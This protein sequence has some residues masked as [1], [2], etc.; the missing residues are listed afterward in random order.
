MIE[1]LFQPAPQ[2]SVEEGVKAL[3]SNAQDGIRRACYDCEDRIRQEPGKAMLA[4]AAAGYL[5]HRLPVRAILVTQ[6]KVLAALARPALVAFGAAKVCEYLQKR[7][8]NSSLPP[9][10]REREREPSFQGPYS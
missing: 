4:A 3:V 1:I 9:R 2:Q 5:L 6:V 7:H 10:T 8:S